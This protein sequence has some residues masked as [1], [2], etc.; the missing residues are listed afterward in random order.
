MTPPAGVLQRQEAYDIALTGFGAGETIVIRGDPS[1]DSTSVA[2]E[3]DGTATVRLTVGAAVDANEYTITA[4]GQE[5]GTVA[6]G[7]V[8]VIVPELTVAAAEIDLGG[9]VAVDGSGF[10]PNA[11]ITLNVSPGGQTV[12]ASTDCCSGTF[13]VDSP[14]FTTPGT[15]TIQ[16]VGFAAQAQVSVRPPPCV[17]TLTMT[18][19]DVVVPA[20]P[21]FAER[22]DSVPVLSATG[23]PAGATATFTRTENGVRTLIRTVV[24]DQNG[25]ATTDTPFSTGTF[26]VSANGC[27]DGTHVVRA[28]RIN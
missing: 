3:A 18:S 6:R 19:R 28:P 7:T 11:E 5:T 25:A 26:V 13:E 9:D 24:A 15:Y 8:V 4:T 27:E 12:Q 14:V 21:P 1:P 23:L 16:A 22:T 10:P 17:L 20:D 2:A